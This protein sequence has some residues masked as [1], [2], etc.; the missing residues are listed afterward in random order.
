MTRTCPLSVQQTPG[1]PAVKRF[2]G[3]ASGNVGFIKPQ[4]VYEHDYKINNA[5]KYAK[6]DAN[7]QW[8]TNLPGAYRDTR[9]SDD[10]DMLDFTVGS[11][12][13][14]QLDGK[15][16]Y[17]ISTHIPLSG[18]GPPNTG[19]TLAAQISPN[20]GGRGAAQ[21]AVAGGCE[22]QFNPHSTN[23]TPSLG[24]GDVGWC[25]GVKNPGKTYILVSKAGFGIFATGSC[26]NWK[27]AHGFTPC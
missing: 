14:W 2:V 19:A 8:S 22:F 4:F 23:Q 27:F 18:G 26:R 25:G 10:G 13:T 11:L 15:K 1:Y 7:Y 24:S 20:D 6:T 16:T 3:Y 5:R 9:A 21:A 12:F 17:Y